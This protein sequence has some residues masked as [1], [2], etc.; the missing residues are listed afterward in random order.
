MLMAFVVTASLSL[1]TTAAAQRLEERR[2]T[3]IERDDDAAREERERA[4]EEQERG[5]EEQERR[6]AEQERTQADQTYER[7]RNSIERE[8]WSQAVEQ[9]SV[10]VNQRA[11]RADAALYWRAYA[12]DKLSRQADA[13]TSVAELLKSYPASRW[14]GDAKAL[15]L[16][17]RQRGGQ[18]VSPD[19]Q[20]DDDLKLLA[21]QGLQHSNPEQAVPMLE[22]LLQG[23]QSPRLKERALF[24][25][26][27]SGSPRAQDVIA[28]IARGSSNPD[29][30]ER[31]IQYLG[32]NSN[33]ANRQL[34]SEIYQ[35]SNDVAIKRQVLRAFML[36]GDQLRVL[37]AA[38]TEKS[39]ELRGEAV[40]QLGV[41]GAR[42]Q[43]W[44]LYRKE[45][46]PE[47]KRRL[48]E[49]MGISGDSAHLT[50]VANSETDPVVLRSAIRQLGVSG[51]SRAA[52]ALVAI[53]GRQ[54]DPAIRGAALDGLFISNNADALVALARK[55]PDQSMKRRIVEKLSLMS[56]PPARSYMLELLEK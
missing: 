26:A 13:L 17:I 20:A 53:Y 36:S 24:V 22:K 50:E 19:T 35:S 56:A 10:V 37:N 49:A 42:D 52:D 28:R 2:F 54:K 7:G 44:L 30:Q 34:L 15:E 51:G 47:I 25:L 31:A 45:Q 39:D 33:E 3:F 1:V 12:L 48:V 6:R 5:R 40:R 46:S 32:V 9:L 21:I 4:R 14:L 29:L 16:Q 23:N 27:Q 11:S 18:P 38:T 41:M 43:L 55:E 8:Q